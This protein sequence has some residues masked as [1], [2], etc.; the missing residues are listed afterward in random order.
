MNI[1]AILTVPTGLLAICLLVVVQIISLS[2]KFARNR[3][4]RLS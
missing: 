1:L 3:N 2:L 4:R